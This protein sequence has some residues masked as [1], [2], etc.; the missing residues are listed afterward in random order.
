MDRRL[1]ESVFIQATPSL[2]AFVESRI[3]SSMRSQLAAEDVLQDVWILAGRNIDTFEPE[4]EHAIER[5]L[6]R[7][8]KNALIDRIKAKSRTKRS[9][10]GMRLAGM[11]GSSM[12]DLFATVAA[13][14]RSPSKDARSAEAER[15]LVHALETLP[16]NRRQAIWMKY[17]EELP[18]CVIAERMVKT[19]SAVRSLLAQGLTQLR[20]HLGRP[21]RFFSDSGTF[22]S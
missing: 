22:S 21:G 12:L 14:Q 11:G 4:G 2:L 8:T 18:T 5:W 7:I 19:E 10:H 1:L 13:T 9:G 17:I 20:R 3:P 16:L 6:T 15:V